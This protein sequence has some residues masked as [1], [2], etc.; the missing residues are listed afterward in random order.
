[1]EFTHRTVLRHAAVFVALLLLPLLAMDAADAA[2][3]F[4][5]HSVFF[6]SLVLVSL[7]AGWGAHIAKRHDIPAAWIA[8]PQTKPADLPYT[9]RLLFQWAI[10]SRCVAYW[11][12]AA[13]IGTL[14]LLLWP[15]TGHSYWAVILR[16]MYFA[17]MSGSLA[18]AVAVSL[19]LFGDTSDHRT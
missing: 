11:S 4:R 2:L 10:C 15:I 18:G 19:H 14:S 9:R 13:L 16:T 3:W 7:A 5:L 8:Q 12:A 17:V 1:M 6:V